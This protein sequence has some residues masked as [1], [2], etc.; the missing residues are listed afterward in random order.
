MSSGRAPLRK[1]DWKSPIKLMKRNKLQKM[2]WEDFFGD[3]L[4]CEDYIYGLVEES[5]ADK[6]VPLLNF[7]YTMPWETMK[8]FGIEGTK[9][10]KEESIYQCPW[11]DNKFHWF[12]PYALI[13]HGSPDVYK[14]KEIPPYL[15]HFYD[16]SLDIEWHSAVSIFEDSGIETSLYGHGYTSGTLPSDGSGRIWKAKIK[17]SNGDFIAGHLWVWYNK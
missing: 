11:T 10:L 1:I 14:P 12:V 5:D 13:I 6:M 17:L 2:V 7:Y 3:I 16:Y 4:Y 8:G 15:K 9:E